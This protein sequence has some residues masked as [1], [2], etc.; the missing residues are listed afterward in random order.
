MK[1]VKEVC[2]LAGVSART[3]RYYDRIGLL[4]P[5][6]VTEAG[7]RLYDRAA[8]DKLQ[9]ILLF[10]ELRFKLQDI[11]V[12]LDRPDFDAHAALEKQ[13]NLLVLEKERL[14][15]VITLAEQ[16]KK[17]GEVSM[18]FSAFDRAETERYRKEVQ[19]RWGETDAFRESEKRAKIRTEQEENDLADGMMQ[20]FA[21]FGQVKDRDASSDEAQTLV[22]ELQTY[23]TAHY[24][25]CTDEILKG[26]GQM[27]TADERFKANINQA[28][29]EGTAEFVAAAIYRK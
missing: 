22:T 6:A 27:Y 16:L 2:D 1:T 17:G 12:I 24:Y 3:L 10:R 26:L 20:I 23:I 21:K 18:D 19:E 14:E 29:G 25:P 9:Q 13:I 15:K 8:L 4:K 7:Y 5:T 28:G 11:K